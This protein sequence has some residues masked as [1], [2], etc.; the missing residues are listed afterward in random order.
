[1]TETLPAS[2]SGRPPQVDVEVPAKAKRRSFPIGCKQRIV[3]EADASIAPG[4]V[5][6]LLRREELYPS[7]LG[8]WS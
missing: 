1:M 6:A 2:A 3:A 4:A 5:G 7:L 8:S